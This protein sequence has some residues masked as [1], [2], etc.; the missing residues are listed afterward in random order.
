MGLI[1]MLSRR[2]Q[3]SILQL[4][5]LMLLLN[6]SSLAAQTN[7]IDVLAYTVNSGSIEGKTDLM[8]YE[9]L[10]RSR[11]LLRS[12][13][14]HGHFKLSKNRQLAFSSTKDGNTDI[15]VTDTQQS[16]QILINISQASDAYDYP[17]GWSLDGKYL[18]FA[19]RTAGDKSIYI[20]DSEKTT[21][22]TP[23]N[24]NPVSRY[25]S[26]DIAWNTKNELAFTIWQ[27]T[28]ADGSEIYYWDG[29]EII[30]ISQTPF[31]GDNSP[32]WNTNGQLAFSSLRNGKYDIFVW[33][34]MSFKNNQ[35]DTDS[36][37]NIAPELTDYMSSPNWTNKGLLAFNATG[38]DDSHVQ[39]Y[40]W[41][42]Q[43]VTNISQNPDLHNG[44]PTWSADGRWAFSTFWSSKQLVYVKDVN[45]Q[46]IFTTEAEYPPAWSSDGNL[47]YCKRGPKGWELS[48]WD[49]KTISKV[50]EGWDISAQWSSGSSVFCSSG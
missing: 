5:F 14:E 39:V 38:A 41:N 1:F 28:R 10:S 47:A 6:V 50:S 46:T 34:A 26:D 48:V 36:F 9:P 32:V 30:D 17:L 25:F 27:P 33:D 18:A 7:F 4:S 22:I 43:T 24:T 3:R 42:G 31:G 40:V 19:S 49:G 37:I 12:N 2:H 8:L 45:N 21:N 44:F 13:V 20:W 16:D 35:V 15:Y 29:R 23:P 11:S